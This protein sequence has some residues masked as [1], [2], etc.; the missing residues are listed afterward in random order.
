MFQQIRLRWNHR[1]RKRSW[2]WGERVSD[3]SD[4]C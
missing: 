3:E 2:R 1:M 4:R